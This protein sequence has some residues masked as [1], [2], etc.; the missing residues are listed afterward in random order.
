M[1]AADA[2]VQDQLELA[3]LAPATVE[4]IDALRPP[5]NARPHPVNL[6][7]DAP[8]VR[9]EAALRAVLA[10]PGVDAALMLFVPQAATGSVEAAGAIVAAAA[11]GGHASRSPR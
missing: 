2:V 6:L 10:D 11:A 5:P 3:R 9:I 4:A 1:I 8:P 7:A